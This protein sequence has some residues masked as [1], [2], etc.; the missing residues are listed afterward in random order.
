VIKGVGRKF[1]RGGSQR[2]KYQKLAKNTKRE[3]YL[4][5]PGGGG[6]EKK[7]LKNSKKGRK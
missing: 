4:P 6:N 5:R 1:S 2:K 3:H 7:R